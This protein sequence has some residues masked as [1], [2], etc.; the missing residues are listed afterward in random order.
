MRVHRGYLFWGIFFVLL[1]GIPLA[2][3]QGWVDPGQ[4]GL[5][6]RLWPLIV[7]AIGLA[8]VL[9]R[10]RIALVGTVVTA[11]VLGTMAG[12][13]LA[14]GGGWVL[15]DCSAGDSGQL[16]ATT[17]TGTFEGRASVELTTSCGT[18]DVTPAAGQGWVLQ[19]DHRGA[20]PLV[21]SAPT[22]LAVRSADGSG[23]QEWTVGVPLALLDSMSVTASAMQ[24][25]IDVSGATM[26]S[27][28][29]A[30]NAGAAVL[31]A[32]GAAIA[33]LVV[34]VNA[35]SVRITLGGPTAGSITANA[36]S[37][38]LCVPADAALSVRITDQL[39]FATNLGQ[40]G[41]TQ[42]GDTWL[43]AGTGG[44]QVTLTVA[45]NAADLELDPPGG[46][47]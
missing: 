34:T 44:P 43:R 37:V 38:D 11:L 23:R 28:T 22:R 31:D 3:R 5:T 9:S 25:D 39:A 14:V 4:S 29:L 10:S 24:T 13:M 20:P 30:E 42:S 32:S 8:I 41:L 33:H 47:R 12:S 40:R 27:M 45:G 19:A 6:G 26:S 18:L 16:Q 17:Q 21:D 15:G 7:V 36:G 46:C 35:G 2:D 1:G